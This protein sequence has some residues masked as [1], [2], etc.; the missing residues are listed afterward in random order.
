[1]AI[2]TM[3]KI[4]VTSKGSLKLTSRINFGRRDKPP[5]ATARKGLTHPE[6]YAH[7]SPREANNGNPR[8]ICKI[9]LKSTIRH[10][11]DVNEYG[12]LSPLPTLN[13]PYSILRP[14]NHWTGTSKCRLGNFKILSQYWRDLELVKIKS[15]AF[16]MYCH[17][18]YSYRENNAII[19]W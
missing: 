8:T 19:R 18:F 11:N 15:G 1:M 6:R 3:P 5:P 14:F 13:T 7:K 4:E 2:I 17:G 16:S 10:Q 9:R 12:L